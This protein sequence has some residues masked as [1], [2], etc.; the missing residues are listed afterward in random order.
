M[1]GMK[2][3]LSITTHISD[4]KLLLTVYTSTLARNFISTRGNISLSFVAGQGKATFIFASR[5]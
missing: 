3:N 4:I 2:S 1:D 5:R